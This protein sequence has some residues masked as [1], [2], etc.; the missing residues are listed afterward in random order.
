VFGRGGAGNTEKV[1]TSPANNFGLVDMHGNAMEWCADWSGA[2]PAE[3]AANPRGPFGGTHRIL[4][5]GPFDAQDYRCR[6]DFRTLRFPSHASTSMD[7]RVVCD[8][9]GDEK[10]PEFVS[11][12][13]GKDLDGWKIIH[14]PDNSEPF[15]AVTEDGEPALRSPGKAMRIG[16]SIAAADY[17]HLRLEAKFA[18]GETTPRHL[19][20]A[21]R[22]IAGS[23]DFFQLDSK[24]AITLKCTGTMLFDEA[25]V[26][27]GLIEIRRKEV[28]TVTK[29][30]DILKKP[31]EWNLIEVFVIGED[32]IYRVN[33]RVVCA[34]ANFRIG[35]DAPAGGRAITLAVG[36]GMMFFRRIEMRPIMGLPPDFPDGP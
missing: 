13:N 28:K 20:C 10:S 35:N 5:G 34:A 23:S 3:P 6:T 36:P 30:G 32:T 19:Q 7:F 11:L 2:Y 21:V 9:P 4:R 17:Y 24:P 14:N 1:G 26:S 18:T 8:A 16:P 31:G 15:K 25:T 12:F 22:T 27:S 33:G 29:P